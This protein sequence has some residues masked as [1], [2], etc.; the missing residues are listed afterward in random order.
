MTQTT[1]RIANPACMWDPSKATRPIPTVPV[2]ALPASTRS[3]PWDGEKYPGGYGPTDI[4]WPDYWTLRER[5]A[6]L[7]RTNLYARGIIRRLVTNIINTGLHLEATP[8]ERVLGLEED[9]L[10]DWS[11]TTEARFRLWAMSPRLCDHTGQHTFGALQQIAK[12]EA[13]V[14]GDVLVVARQDQRTGLPRLQLVNGSNVQTPMD[15]LLDRPGQNRVRSGVELDA[16]GRQV[17]YHVVQA[18]RTS[19][20]LP[21]F[22]PKSGRRIAWLVYGNERR[23]DDVRGEPLLAICL[24]SLREI[25]RYRDSTQRKALINSYLAMFIQ[26][27]EERMGTGPMGGGASRRGLDT[28]VDAQGTERTFKTAEHIPGLVLDELQ[29]GEKPQA[30]SSQGTDEK[31]GDFEEA[32]VQAVS[33][34]YE[35][36][37]EILR[38][39]FSSNYSASQ[40]AIN[41]FKMYLNAARED[42]GQAFCQPAYQEWLIS[43][44]MANKLEAQELFE[45]MIDPKRAETVAAWMAAD[46]TGQIKPAVDKSKLVK[47]YEQEIAM[48]CNTRAR[49]CRE[50]SGQ[51]FSRVIRQLKREN[52]ALAEA[53]APLEPAPAPL[54]AEPD[55]DE[56]DLDEERDEDEVDEE[57][58]DDEDNEER[59]A[60]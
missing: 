25:D 15:K 17:A 23:L 33:W 47:G 56:L 3:M 21:A 35:I 58:V 38:L 7:W 41:E 24:Q 40:A 29:F 49:V 31:F 9:A 26:K 27:D 8:E 52:E 57:A 13:C 39:S 30:F 55:E 11:E 46:W 51:K 50:L 59:A 10:A 43:E 2:A 5:S 20:R 53:L 34:H 32:I 14:V 6:T 19:K 18:D 1:H 37:P 16:S 28:L 36:P 54:P 60:V 45:A 22:G 48:G 44:V 12:R 42:F 4:V